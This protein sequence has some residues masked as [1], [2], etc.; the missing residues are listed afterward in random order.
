MTDAEGK[1]LLK[2][3]RKHGDKEAFEVLTKANLPLVYALSTKFSAKS[4]EDLVRDGIVG[5]IESYLTF[6]FK[7]ATSLATWATYYIRGAMLR[8]VLY[9]HQVNIG[10]S[11]W[12]RSLFYN[13]GRLSKGRDEDKAWREGVA[14]NLGVSVDTLEIAL[15][16]FKSGDM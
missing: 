8:H 13:Y 12:E 7:R 10:K 1:K 2:R 11:R 3:Y 4:R 5:L 14:K 16:R 6:D 15:A 9:Q